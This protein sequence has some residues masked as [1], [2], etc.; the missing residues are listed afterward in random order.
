MTVLQ[1]TTSWRPQQG[2]AHEKHAHF[3]STLTLTAPIV[4]QLE[5][6]SDML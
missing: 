5:Q 1:R 2:L 4:K 3:M 6:V